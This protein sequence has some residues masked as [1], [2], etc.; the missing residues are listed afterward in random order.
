[1]TIE[2]LKS[3]EEKKEKLKKAPVRPCT[4][5]EIQEIRDLLNSGSPM[6][7]AFEEFLFIGGKYTALPLDIEFR[8]IKG[9]S[10]YVKEEMPKRGI[11]MDRPI[12][13][14]HQ[15][16]GCCF[17]F[18]YLDEGDNP[19]PWMC[20]TDEEFDTD[21]GEKMWHPPFKTFKED[22]DEMVKL[23]VAGQGI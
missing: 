21:E 8:T 19:T 7:K 5:E 6:P 9:W 1:M 15:H 4:L 14:F 10:L 23:A 11:K 12:A 16:E 17:E 22:I 3:Y 13:V 2:Y 20:S 18:I